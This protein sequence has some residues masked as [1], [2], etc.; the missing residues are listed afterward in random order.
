[1]AIDFQNKGDHTLNFMKKLDNIVMKYNGAIY[2][3]KDARMSKN[4]F[5]KSFSKN[6][7]FRKFID[8]KISSFFLERVK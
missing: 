4:I 1:M 5:E 3:A 8:P 2:P 7:E 6:A